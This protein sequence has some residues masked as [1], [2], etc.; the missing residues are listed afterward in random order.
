MKKKTQIYTGL[1]V[2]QLPKET[3]LL[4]AIVVRLQNPNH[5]LKKKETYLKKYINSMTIEIK[6]KIFQF[7]AVDYILFHGV[8]NIYILNKY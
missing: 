3:C 4:I 8:D 2:N 5:V 7:A 6:L 1:K